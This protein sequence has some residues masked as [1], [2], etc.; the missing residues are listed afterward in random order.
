MDTDDFV[1]DHASALRSRTSRAS[2]ARCS[3]CRR[4]VA[5]TTKDVDHRLL[6]VDL[7]DENQAAR[8]LKNAIASGRATPT[9]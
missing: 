8:D 1:E 6:Y 2:G 7:H 9:P 5:Q 4:L 3:N